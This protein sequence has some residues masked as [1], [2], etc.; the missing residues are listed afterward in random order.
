MRAIRYSRFKMY[1]VTTLVAFSITTILFIIIASSLQDK[2]LDNIIAYINERSSFN[3]SI[4]SLKIKYPLRIQANNVKLYSKT[5][6]NPFL[7]VSDATV[8]INL[9]RIFFKKNPIHIISS[10][11]INDAFLYPYYMSG[12]SLDTEK[13][14]N[15][16]DR[17]KLLKILS[18]FTDKRISINDFTISLSE[19]TSEIS[20]PI[21][22][23]FQ[24]LDAHI[25][26][27]GYT[28]D[29]TI[30]V[31]DETYFSFNLESETNFN[32]LYSSFTAYDEKGKFLDYTLKSETM[33]EVFKATLFDNIDSNE[34]GL[35]KYNTELERSD[36]AITNI[37]ISKAILTKA[38]NSFKKS[39][40][41]E[42][43]LKDNKDSINDIDKLVDKFISAS[44]SMEGQYEMGKPLYATFSANTHDEYFD[45]SIDAKLDNN[46]IIVSNAVINTEIGNI[47]VKGTI[48]IKEPIASELYIETQNI[49][50]ANEELSTKILVK[51]IQ[52][53]DKNVYSKILIDKFKYKEH[54]N[55]GIVF[56]L[57][58]KKDLNSLDININKT[59]S[60]QP[61]NIKLNLNSAS[62]T[63]ASVKGVLPQEFLIA[64]V[65]YDVL[66]PLSEIYI[67]YALSNKNT[68]TDNVSVSSIKI[69][70]S[71]IY[72]AESIMEF[73]ALL[74]PDKLLV[75]NLFVASGESGIKAKAQIDYDKNLNVTINGEVN[76]P[77]G[78]YKLSGYTESSDNDRIFYAAT[79]NEEIVAR[80]FIS[81][82]G[83][84]NFNIDT[85]K[86]IHYKNI[87]FNTK[88]TIDNT[89]KE[90]KSLY[91][92][93]V[94]NS[95]SS[96]APIFTANASFEAS[97]NTLAFTNIIYDYG[98]NTLVGS[99]VLSTEDGNTK[100]TAILLSD[101]GDG[102]LATEISINQSRI[103][104]T[105]ATRKLPLNTGSIY[106]L[107]DTKATVIGN[108]NDP[109]VHLEE[110]KINALEIK[111]SRYDVSLQGFLRKDE[112]EIKNV[113]M[114]KTGKDGFV[115]TGK[116]RDVIAIPNAYFSK[117][118]Q[119]ISINVTNLYLLS[120]FSGNIDYS[121][122]TLGNGNKE[123]R[124]KTT[125][126]DVNHRTLKSF[127]TVA[128][129][130]GTNIVFLSPETHG[131]RGFVNREDKKI[132]ADLQYMFDNKE[133]LNIEGSIKD[134][135]SDQVDMLVT[136]DNLTTEIFELFNTLFKRIDSKPTNFVVE[137][138]PYTLYAKLHGDIDDVKITG[139]FLG[140]AKKIKMQ[141]FSDVFTETT[142]DFIFEGDS[143]RVAALKFSTSK[144]KYLELTGDAEL[145]N[146]FVN[147]MNFDVL[148]SD[149]QVGLLNADANL[150][151]LKA[152]GN[153][154]IDMNIGGNLTVPKMTGNIILKRNDI[155]LIIKPGTTYQQHMYSLASEVYWDLNIEALQSVRVANSLVGDLYIEDG[156]T[157]RV[158]NSVIDNIQL[159]GTMNISRG[160]IYYLQ[161]VYTI[162]S[163]SVTFPPINSIDPII[164]AVAYTQTRY[165]QY[166]GSSV[167]IDDGGYDVT[168][169]MEMN[170]R[171]SQL[172]FDVNGGIAPIKFY[173]I[174]ALGQYQVNQLAG[175]PQ[176]SL[177][178]NTESL[179]YAATTSSASASLQAD[180][181]RIAQLTMSYSELAIKSTLLRPVERWIR[182]FIGID[183]INLNP[184]VVGNLINDTILNGGESISTLSVLDNTSVSIGKYVSKDL[185]FK[186]DITYRFNDP[187]RPSNLNRPDDP[188]FFDHQFGFEVFLLR[189]LKLANLSFEYKINPFELETVR[190]EFNLVTRWRF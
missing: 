109:I 3:I 123:Y 168:L 50:I 117:D 4:S 43:L 143:A 186:Y 91:L 159:E 112:V 107:I 179:R 82:K 190:Q 185:Y 69:K 144:G 56:N 99:G 49:L 27:N 16:S 103:Y 15:R 127:N 30:S 175:V 118:L 129:D 145:N 85:P 178:E 124:I 141:Y 183:Y 34:V 189:H 101:R 55:E 96:S 26:E 165:Y 37:I 19:S 93:G 120:T 152:K 162:E 52:I 105:L 60:I 111:G 147:Y 149:L 110:F 148:T 115:V 146:N 41:A 25:K 39:T 113:Y 33:G 153:V 121:K 44:L 104:A 142:A 156:Q 14:D 38:L 155:Q 31:L 181:D 54:I 90:N 108:L 79:E 158:Y 98:D 187:S 140:S 128:I 7:A 22:V 116:N 83:E 62:A 48:P 68:T 131:I 35:L 97:N 125:P 177:E 122:R 5:E 13:K 78:D 42:H 160:S 164:K 154:H 169:Y 63:R 6:D 71:K 167:S 2:Y 12:L 77:L 17:E 45:M 64:L 92:H 100:L 133:L 139:R 81:E 29:S 61:L 126:I 157:L 172:L 171:I 170:S 23:V 130:N 89:T 66:D 28:L 46:N 32:N 87:V 95:S 94:I 8:S 70:S 20:K 58:Y 184:A 163:G 136:S 173:T 151:I 67:D 76:T 150:G 57:N 132:V 182:Q 73:D 135:V 176:T 65:G 74:Y 138:K 11:D 21:Q 161:N 10:L 106:G 18:Y 24:T 53:T 9:F 86:S 80:G 88:I 47:L 174:P 36:F 51:P 75:N 188:Y 72:T 137:G 180:Q 166:T 134:A 59:E 84:I 1:V 102:A 119:S 114:I 40:I